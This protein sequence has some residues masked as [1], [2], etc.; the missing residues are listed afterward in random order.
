MLLGNACSHKREITLEF[1]KQVV[2]HTIRDSYREAAR[3][4]DIND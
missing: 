1:E 4:Y 2:E 3:K